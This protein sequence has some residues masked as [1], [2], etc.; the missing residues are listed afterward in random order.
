MMRI[1]PLRRSL[2]AALCLAVPVCALFPPALSAQDGKSGHTGTVQEAPKP[3][4]PD[5]REYV[6][7]FKMTSVDREY[8]VRYAESAQR[9]N[10]ILTAIRNMTDP[11]TKIFLVP[12]SGM[13]VVHAPEEAQTQIAHLLTALDQP[14]S[15]YQLTYTFTEMDGTHKIGVQHFQI[16]VLSGERTE[17]NQGSR[18]PVSTGTSSP[19]VIT[20]FTYL[21]VGMHIDVTLTEV[22]GG[23]ILKSKVEQNSV[24][25]DNNASM[26]QPVLRR[27]LLEG[28][29]SL[30]N[31]K[32][33]MIGSLDVPSSTRH[34]D[35]E[36]EMEPVR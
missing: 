36:V 22:Q 26:P 31:G 28:T 4:N 11:M 23:G 10:E 5:S 34:I 1:A 21:D 27:T 2:L 9:Q 24:A 13:I 3:L 14:R 35:V 32:P 15:R 30:L 19:G 20:Q 17:L 29:A 33:L 12:S 16:V 6:E 25:Q 18:L 8:K 7:H